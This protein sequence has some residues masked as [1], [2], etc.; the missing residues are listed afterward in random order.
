MQSLTQCAKQGIGHTINDTIIV[1][2]HDT[3]SLKDT[4]TRTLTLKP[5][6]N[7]G[8][9][10]MVNSMGLYAPANLSGNPKISASA[11]TYYAQGYSFGISRG[12]IEFTALDGLP[13][14]A[15]I[16]SATLYLSGIDGNKG[17]PA[18][19]GN[20]LYP[21]SPY[22]NYTDNSC[23]LKRVTGNWNQDSI[24]WNHMPG[25][26]DQNEAGVPGSTKQFDNNATVNVTALVQD[27]V[28][29][30]QNYGF[31]LELQNEQI[32]RSLNF[33]GSRDADSTRW[34][35]LVVTYN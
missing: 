35:K 15:H 11:W 33:S 30:K 6:P 1:K 32:Y 7:D 19:D 24:T 16:Q 12:Y 31:C 18:T 28:T 5:G 3:T 20:S 9:D 2:V 27:I 23:W 29:S 26:T 34:P 4:V 21:G 25:T 8:Q 10:C 17:N 13:D 14:S 22:S